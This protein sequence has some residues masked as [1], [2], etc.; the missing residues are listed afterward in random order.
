MGN[1][2]FV[3]PANEKRVSTVVTEDPNFV[4]GYLLFKLVTVGSSETVTLNVYK[5]N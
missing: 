1:K 2:I 4:E 3:R 5:L